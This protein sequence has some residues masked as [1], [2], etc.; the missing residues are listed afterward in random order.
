MRAIFRSLRTSTRTRRH[1]IQ[2]LKLSDILKYSNLYLTILWL[3]L[4][5]PTLLWWKDSILWV[6]LM[7]IWANVASHF[8]A[9]IAARFEE[10]QQQGHNLTEADR[11]WIQAQLSTTGPLGDS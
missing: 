5:F 10:Q 11:A 1:A 3:L 8:A 6:A 4:I 7:S 2:A 9:Y